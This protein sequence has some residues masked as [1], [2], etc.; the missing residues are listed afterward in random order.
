MKNS[1]SMSL[2]KLWEIVE[3]REAWHVAVHGVAKSRTR[4][5]ETQQQ[6]PLQERRKRE[7]GKKALSFLT[8]YHCVLC[9][10]REPV[11]F[12]QAPPSPWRIFLRTF[13]R[14][15]L[16]SGWCCLWN[17]INED[18]KMTISSPSAPFQR[19]FVKCICKPI[20][21]EIL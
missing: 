4:L 17:D 20:G 14:T 19:I 8:E 12:I 10:G 7:R 2:S 16:G 21:A 15:D 3:D 18:A 9:P 13:L 6:Q 5:S 11:H 1:P